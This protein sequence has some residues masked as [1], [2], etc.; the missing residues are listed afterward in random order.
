[1][2]KALDR[3]AATAVTVAIAVCMI[4]CGVA[5]RNSQSETADTVS[6]SSG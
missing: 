3:I 1:M 5:D 4:G 6:S 2:Y